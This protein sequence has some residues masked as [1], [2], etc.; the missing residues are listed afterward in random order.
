MIRREFLKLCSLALLP[1]GRFCKRKRTALDLF[2]GDLQRW[3]EAIYKIVLENMPNTPES[4]GV[5]WQGYHSQG[6]VTDVKMKFWDNKHPTTCRFDAMED[7]ADM[8]S[9][10]TSVRNRVRALVQYCLNRHWG[11]GPVTFY[12]KTWDAWSCQTR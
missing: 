1:F 12:G 5:A 9:F 3:K 6:T 11:V 2:D 8:Q 10:E 7:H 4:H